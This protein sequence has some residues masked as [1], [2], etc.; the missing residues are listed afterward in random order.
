MTNTIL[1]KSARFELG[2]YSVLGEHHSGPKPY[3][4]ALFKNLAVQSVQHFTTRADATFA[5]EAL[6]RTIRRNH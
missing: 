4:V 3:T 5:F 1:P 6:C 2:R